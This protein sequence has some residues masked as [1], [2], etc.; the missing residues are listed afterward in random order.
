MGCFGDVEFCA[1]LSGCCAVEPIRVVTAVPRCPMA[2][3]GQGRTLLNLG[4]DAQ[5]LEEGCLGGVEG[6]GAGGD[7]DIALGDGIRARG[8]GLA[9]LLD[10]VLDGP[11]VAADEEQAD[12]AHELWEERAPGVVALVLTVQAD[13]ALHERVLTHEDLAVVRANGLHAVL[14]S[15]TELVLHH[16]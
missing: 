14:W 8:G 15:T 7:V 16:R 3:P 11:K 1:R 9:E 10:D 4:G 6:G 2:V 13:A 5:G 12:V